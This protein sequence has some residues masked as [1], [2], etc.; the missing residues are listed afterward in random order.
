MQFLFTT[1]TFTLIFTTLYSYGL[2]ISKNIYNNKF[3]DIFFKILIGYTFIGTLTLVVHFFFKIN[4]LISF[5]IVALGVIFFVLS[6][7]KS[8]KKEFLTILFLI[9]LLS[10]LFY[11]YSDHPID[12]NM[13]HHPYISYLKSEKIIFGIANIQFRFGHISFLQYVQSALTNDYLHTH[14]Q[15]QLNSK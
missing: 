5:L 11:G 15:K 7:F 14:I 6:Y 8:H 12:A 9:I 10:P 13:Y 1:I 2:A 4:N 3:E